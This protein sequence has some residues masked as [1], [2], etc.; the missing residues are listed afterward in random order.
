MGH[1]YL[2]GMDPC[3]AGRSYSHWLP[4]RVTSTSSGGSYPSHHK[5]GLFGSRGLFLGGTTL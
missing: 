2:A 5:A 4:D 3:G 1:G